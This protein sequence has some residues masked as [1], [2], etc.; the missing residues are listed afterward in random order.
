MF[1]GVCR[2]ITPLGSSPVIKLLL[3][4]RCASCKAVSCKKWGCA[5]VSSLHILSS[6]D[7]ICLILFPSK[8]EGSKPTR[9]L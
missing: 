7:L 6:F 9:I 1:Q 5:P 3:E 2:C 4:G 8:Q